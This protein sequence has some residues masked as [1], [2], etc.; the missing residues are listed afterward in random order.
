MADMTHSIGCKFC[1]EGIETKDELE[2]IS[3]IQPDYIQG[4]YYGR[5]CPIDE[6]IEQYVNKATA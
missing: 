3:H 4:Y 5:P 6:F 2:R 1:I